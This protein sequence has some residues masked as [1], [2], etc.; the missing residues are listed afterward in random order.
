MNNQSGKFSA[1]STANNNNN[2]KSV[3]GKYAESP[4]LRMPFGMFILGVDQ[5]TE[6]GQKYEGQVSMKYGPDKSDWLKISYMDMKKLIDFC[7]ENKDHF[8][9][10]L[11]K[12]RSKLSTGDL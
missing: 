8:N 3:P 1:S 6:Q 10:M 5:E 11:A 9:G 7:I 2:Q 4:M 12:E